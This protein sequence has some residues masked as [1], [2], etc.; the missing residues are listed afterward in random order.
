MLIGYVRVSKGDDQN[1][2]LQINALKAAGAQKIYTEAA[3]GGRWDRPELHR[4]LEHARAGDVLVV[5]KLD[6]L[7]RSL[8]DLLALLEKLEAAKV[9]FRSVTESIDTTTPA[10]R[11]FAQMVGAF[12][13]YERAMI[14]ERTKAGLAVARAEGRV[15]GR[16]PK[17]TPHQQREIVRG[18]AEGRYTPAAAARLFDVHP[19]TISR[20]L[21]RTRGA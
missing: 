16:R 18:I 20:L 9:G 8:K 1:P 19:A 12:A 2:D 11:M 5:W 13:E 14:R 4:A 6:R 7:S 3:S 10:G 17:L 15:G 21:S